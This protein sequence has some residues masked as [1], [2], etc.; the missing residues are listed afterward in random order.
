[1]AQNPW[2]PWLPNWGAVDQA[3]DR[4]QPLSGDVSQ[5]LRV[6]S[7]TVTVNGRGDPDLE[8]EIVR[9]VATYGAQLGPLT[10][11]VLALAEGTEVPADALAKL[12]E[13]C[14]EIKTKKDEYRLGALDR[15]RDSLVE[16]AEADPAGLAKLLAEFAD[17]RPT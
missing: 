8:G 3:S 15:A 11:L 16:L 10:A 9:D 5:W 13:I 6:F 2:A 7:P 12:R 4:H 1:M 14:L 17:K